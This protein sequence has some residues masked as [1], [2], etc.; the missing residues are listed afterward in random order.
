MLIILINSDLFFKIKDK[1][2]EPG[3]AFLDHIMFSLRLIF[4]VWGS[5]IQSV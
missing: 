3:F 1:M 5:Q 4:K 2:M